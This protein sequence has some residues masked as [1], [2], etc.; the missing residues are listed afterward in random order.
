M[1]TYYVP[2]TVVVS[3]STF[4]LR[5]LGLQLRGLENMHLRIRKEG[6]EGWVEWDK[7]S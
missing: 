5:D 1:S 6:E 4:S 3:A 7:K 2:S